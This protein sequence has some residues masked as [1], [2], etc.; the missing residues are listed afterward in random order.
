MYI[1]AKLF[2]LSIIL[3]FIILPNVYADQKQSDPIKFFGKGIV[4]NDSGL[5]PGVVVWTMINGNNATYVFHGVNGLE[6]IRLVV[7]Q[8]QICDNSQSQICLNGNVTGVKNPDTIVSMGEQVKINIHPTTKQETVGFV[9]GFLK[10]MI[11]Q[12]DLTKIWSE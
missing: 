3:I 9:S 1:F 12:I 11:L 7:T 4:S 6:V 2:A 8:D 5:A 10:D